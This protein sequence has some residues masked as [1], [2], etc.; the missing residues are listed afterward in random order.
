MRFEASDLGPPGLYVMTYPELKSRLIREFYPEGILG[1][2]FTGDD[3]HLV[4]GASGSLVRF[5]LMTGNFEYIFVG[6]STAVLPDESHDGNTI[7]Y[8]RV[9]SSEGTL[10]EFHRETFADSL[11]LVNG[12]ATFGTYPRWSADDSLLAYIEND[13]VHILR[14]STGEGTR[15]TRTDY[16]NSYHYVPRWLDSRHILF[17]EVNSRGRQRYF[18]VD[19]VDGSLVE[20]PDGIYDSEAISPQGDSIV[21]QGFDRSDPNETRVVLFVRAIG[22]PASTAR[23]ITQFIPPLGSDAVRADRQRQQL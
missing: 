19:R 1:L 2:R 15:I 8:G 12:M 10:W 5:N 6:T 14:R 3:T 16:P 22:S 17:N 11:I 13:G 4:S 7:A 18:V 23:Q 20:V 21:V 9:F